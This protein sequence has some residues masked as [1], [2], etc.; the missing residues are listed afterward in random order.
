M[1]Y[2]KKLAIALGGTFIL[3][4]VFGFIPNPIVHAEGLFVTNAMH[5][6]VHLIT[7]MVFLLAVAIPGKES[8]LVMTVGAG[9]L[10]VA[11]L[12]FMVNGDYLL[13]VIEIN[14][15]DRWLHLALAVGILATGRIANQM[16][17]KVVAA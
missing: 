12:G 4:G 2:S 5:N 9:Y 8:T 6:L 11:A 14:Q 15:A 1:Q 3:V 10:A 16:D 13:G 17:S 7:G